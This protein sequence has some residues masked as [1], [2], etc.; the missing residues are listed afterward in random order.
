MARLLCLRP[1]LL[2]TLCLMLDGAAQA[3]ANISAEKEVLDF[4]YGDYE[5]RDSTRVLPGV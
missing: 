2:T 1:V 3:Y 5:K 4:A